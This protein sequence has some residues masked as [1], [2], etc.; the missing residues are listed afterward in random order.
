MFIF[1]SHNIAFITPV[2]SFLLKNMNGNGTDCFLS[3]VCNKSL[4]FKEFKTHIF[5][6]TGFVNSLMSCQIFRV[7][8][9][10]CYAVLYTHWNLL[11]AYVCYLKTPQHYNELKMVKI[12]KKQSVFHSFRQKKNVDL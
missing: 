5:P 12:T 11:T 2:S 10:L 1:V 7:M 4:L 8:S 3:L 9:R 6:F